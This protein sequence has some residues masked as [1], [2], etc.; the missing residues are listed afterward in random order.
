MVPNF[1]LNNLERWNNKSEVSK[2]YKQ[3]SKEYVKCSKI[4]SNF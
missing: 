2:G 4:I 1:M 3:T